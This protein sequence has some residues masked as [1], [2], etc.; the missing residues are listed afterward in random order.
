MAR[1]TTDA[2]LT[3]GASLALLV[4]ALPDAVLLPGVDRWP[5]RH[6][7]LALTGALVSAGWLAA[8]WRGRRALAPRV[9][10]LLLVA[11][12]G[13]GFLSAA[14]ASA[15]RE[16]LAAA[17]REPGSPYYVLVALACLTT[18]A[19][20]CL[21]L[22]ALA[23][24]ALGAGGPRAR[25]ALLLGVALGLVVAPP[26]I[27]VLLA[28]TRTLQLIGLLG[29]CAGVLLLEAPLALEPRRVSLRAA[30]ALAATGGAALVA[31]RQLELG[32][33]RS[34]LVVPLF[35]AVAG[36]GAALAPSSWPRGAVGWLAAA[37][38]AL[39]L[40]VPAEPFV[41]STAGGTSVAALA[42]IAAAALVLGALLG[43]ALA[44]QEGR[45]VPAALVPALL[46]LLLPLVT[47]LLLP[48]LGPRPAL[49]VLAGAAALPLLPRWRAHELPLVAL[50]TLGTLA[51]LGIGARPP[52][53][54][55]AVV[56]SLRLDDALLARVEDPATGRTLVAIDGHAAL[57]VSAGQSRRF[58]HLPLLLHPAPSSVLVVEADSGETA[59]A[60]RW[61]APSTLHWLQPLPI[62]PAWLEHPFL[63]D[64]AP[65]SGSERQFLAIDRNPYDVIVMAPDLR[66]GR[67][68]ALV[69]TVE[70]YA[71]A[72]RRLAPGGLLCQW[73]DLAE[74]DVTDLK[75][76]LAAG[77]Q[78]FPQVYVALD[79]P[80]TR[81]AALAMLFSDR[82]LSVS[83]ARIDERL[84]ASGRLAL[85]Y[86]E[87]G[88][89]GLA[90][91]CLVTADRSLV[92]LLAPREEALHDD[93]PSLGARGALRTGGPDERLEV[94]LRTFAQ[95]R[96][97]PMLW[98]EVPALEQ[99]AAAAIVRD[100]YRSWQ[101]LF[102]GAQG[103]VAAQG[104]AG[105]PFDIETPIETPPEEADALLD[106]LVGL[107][108]WDYLR[109]LVLGYAERLERGGDL[110]A[111]EHY[112][113]TAV[114]K[115]EGSAA[116]R[117]ALA[118]LVE[119]KGDAADALVLYR[120]VLAFEP[121][122]ARALA[123]VEALQAR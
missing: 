97:D 77:E 81:R 91:A 120:T 62:P 16:P 102:G 69:G 11:A 12:L 27:E 76:V 104:A 38:A 60:A 37:I 48:R 47:V 80:R 42:R 64:Q 49:V 26:L 56:D 117:F 106:A 50:L 111:A 86:D 46:V 43:A 95:W 118:S 119:R 33:E 115:D 36:F 121:Q 110:A 10:R 52:A 19:P 87:V 57:G 112:L 21:P 89:D 4:S 61:H 18:A 122:H 23:G 103:V 113:R 88:L 93:R 53:G 25:R 31:C 51:L 1:P 71:L 94:G 3:L 20:A 58:A 32:L 2:C 116:I 99:P 108:D 41:L 109:D 82:P 54:A 59:R 114:A 98:I 14:L 5:P 100:R 30:V 35:A 83:P 67:R 24:V 7:G 40:C 84:A 75:A 13:G 66:A 85:D 79:Q 63:G 78:V 6:V 17:L 107:P 8:T 96:R 92:E 123:R 15:W 28:G 72:Q 105:P 65:T 39:A 44:D 74:T 73:W 90:I 34:A 45:S 68:A 29:A 9:V 55:L 22:G 101:H 70:F